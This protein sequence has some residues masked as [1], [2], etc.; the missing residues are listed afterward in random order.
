[1]ARRPVVEEFQRPL[2]EA[3]MALGILNGMPE[4]DMQKTNWK[5]VETLV[6]QAA[7]PLRG[8]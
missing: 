2:H 1:M 6:G 7:L 8:R 5:G 4:T 3:P